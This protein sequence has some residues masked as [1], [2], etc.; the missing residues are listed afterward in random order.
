VLNLAHSR[1]QKL[2]LTPNSNTISAPDQGISLVLKD[3]DVFT[4]DELVCFICYVK[5][6][7]PSLMSRRP[8]NESNMGDPMKLRRISI[9]SLQEGHVGASSGC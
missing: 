9:S 3:Q 8:R 1:Q 7:P 6:H 5:Q 4:D 2:W